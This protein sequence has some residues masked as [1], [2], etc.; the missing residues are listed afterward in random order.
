MQTSWCAGVRTQNNE[1]PFTD[2]EASLIDAY[3]LKMSRGR[4]DALTDKAILVVK[5]C[6]K[7]YPLAF[8]K[9]ATCVQEAT[10]E[11][12]KR[13]NTCDGMPTNEGVA[14]GGKGPNP[15]KHCKVRCFCPSNRWHIF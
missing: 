13:A 9:A 12:V 4:Y 8:D 6:Y 1:V 3:V 14:F 10:N 15:G 7:K 11:F 5:R 2:K